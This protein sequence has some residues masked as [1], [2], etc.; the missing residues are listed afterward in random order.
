[1]SHTKKKE[2]KG[3]SS[4]GKKKKKFGEGI[5]HCV[6]RREREILKLVKKKGGGCFEGAPCIMSIEKQKNRSVLD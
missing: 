4:R 5:R 1:M 3:K 2:K 6:G